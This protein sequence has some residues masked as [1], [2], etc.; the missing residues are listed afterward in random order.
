VAEREVGAVE[1]KRGEEQGAAEEVDSL[2]QSRQFGL[3]DK[4]LFEV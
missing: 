3:A 1:K 4:N 2:G